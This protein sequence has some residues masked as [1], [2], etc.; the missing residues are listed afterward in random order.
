MVTRLNPWRWSQ[1]VFELQLSLKQLA[2]RLA[3]P[4]SF[5]DANSKLNNLTRTVFERHLSSDETDLLSEAL[6]GLDAGPVEKVGFS[7]L[8]FL[9]LGFP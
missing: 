9:S 7:C 2:I 6:K 5:M 3:S 1:S 4:I 8:F